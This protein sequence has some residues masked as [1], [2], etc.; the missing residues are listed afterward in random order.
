MEYQAFAGAREIVAVAI[1][2]IPESP[3]FT[4]TL[5]LHFNTFDELEGFVVSVLSG[6]LFETSIDAGVGIT[7]TNELM[8]EFQEPMAKG[9][10]SL[11]CDGFSVPVFLE[12]NNISA[13]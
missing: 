4:T 11:C 10:M 6:S 1:L 7:F 2:S 5:E 13:L 12:E 9:S 3:P 8:N